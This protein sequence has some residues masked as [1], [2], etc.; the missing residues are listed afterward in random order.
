LLSVALIALRA[1]LLRA[2]GGKGGL[3][4]REATL[5]WGTIVLLVSAAVILFGTSL[6]ILSKTR[7]EPAFYDTANLPVAVLM[8]LLI[9]YSLYMRWESADGAETLRRSLTSLGASALLCVVLLAA[10]L[11]DPGSLPL[12]FTAI[13]ALV[14]NVRLGAGAARTDWRSLGGKIA[15]IGVAMFLVG[16]IVTG[17]YSAN[18]QVTLPLYN[19][20]TVLGRSLTY[21][22]Y[23]ERRDGALVFSISVTAPGESFTLSPVMAPGGEQGV[24]RTPAIASLLT[25]DLYVSPVGVQ[26]EASAAGPAGASVVPE[27]L[28]AEFS[29]KL[30]AVSI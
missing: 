21:T 14:V 17:R 4:T 8:A 1:R 5:G 27:S 10:G 19:P 25:R 7:V 11:R 13:F 24:L 23:T 3:L 6:P 30:E 15:H 9:G 16:V 18:E 28:V 20:R 22:G 2:T 26:S 12:I 29:V